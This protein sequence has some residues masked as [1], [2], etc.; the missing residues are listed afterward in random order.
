MKGIHIKLNIVDHPY[1]FVATTLVFTLSP[2]NRLIKIVW[3]VTCQPNLHKILWKQSCKQQITKH[4]GKEAREYWEKGRCITLLSNCFLPWN[5]LWGNVE[6]PFPA[7]K[8]H[9]MHLIM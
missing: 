7:R 8:W 4:G 1:S 5:T 2:K 6:N 9:T 3:I